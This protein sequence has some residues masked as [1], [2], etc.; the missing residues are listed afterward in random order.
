M[1]QAFDLETSALD[2]STH[3]ANHSRSA[4][5][6]TPGAR[7]LNALEVRDAWECERWGGSKGAAGNESAV[8][9]VHSFQVH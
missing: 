2:A 9:H 3:W 8:N 6:R 5:A 7:E 1:A 4:E